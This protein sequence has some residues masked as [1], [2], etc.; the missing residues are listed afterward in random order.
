MYPWEL[1][2]FICERNYCLGGDDLMKATSIQENPQLI[3]IEYK[4]FDNKY[5]MWDNEG[6]TYSFTAMPYKEAQEK[7]LVKKLVKKEI[8]K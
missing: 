8:K 3:G 1:E 7:G 6:N 5:Y 2:R 4:P